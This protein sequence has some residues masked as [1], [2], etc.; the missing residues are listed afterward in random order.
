MINA[1]KKGKAGERELAHLLTSLGYPSRRGQ[2]H[3]GGGDSPDV[4]SEL[5]GVHI[6]CKR[7]NGLSIYPAL[8]QAT[9]D[10]A[11]GRIPVVMHR[12]TGKPDWVV[13][14]RVSDLVELI[15]DAEITRLLR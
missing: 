7:T 14:L 5:P 9:R 11:P 12:G 4:V 13:V 15:R 2:Q 6:E 8:A 10:A 1:C 3:A